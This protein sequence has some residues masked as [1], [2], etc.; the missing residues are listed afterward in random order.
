MKIITPVK[1]NRRNSSDILLKKMLNL[2]IP[3][4]RTERKANIPYHC[5][6]GISQGNKRGYTESTVF[7]KCNS[8]TGKSG[9]VTGIQYFV[10]ISE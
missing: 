10:K 2:S 7:L 5:F 9:G 1:Y 6:T 4:K 3:E 8:S